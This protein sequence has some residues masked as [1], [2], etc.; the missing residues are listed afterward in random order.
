VIDVNLTGVFNG[1]Q[2]VLPTMQDRKDGLIVNIASMA[3]K[4]VSMV[5]GAAYTAS[6]FGVVSLTHSINL[7]QWMYGIRACAIC[8]GEVETPILDQRP[9]PIPEERRRRILQSEDI[10]AAVVFVATLPP[11]AVISEILIEPRMRT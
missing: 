9:E 7:E 2:A 5:G 3:G 10:A 6:K 1:A 4:R 8:P 11:R